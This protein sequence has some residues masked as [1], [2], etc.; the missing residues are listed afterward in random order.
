M[1][2]K[3]KKANI[4]QSE[5]NKADVKF[6]SLIAQDRHPNEARY[7]EK[8]WD[9]QDKAVKTMR[10]AEFWWGGLLWTSLDN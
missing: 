7:K 10:V 1:K 9:L 5:Y 6:T 8:L 3:V 2:P 4:L